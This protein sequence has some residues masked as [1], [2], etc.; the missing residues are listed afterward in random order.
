M[1]INYDGKCE[2]CGKNN[3]R[4]TVRVNIGDPPGTVGTE[5][6]WLEC[7]QGYGEKERSNFE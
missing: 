7:V 2:Q 4:V 3:P 5:E 6:R 1:S